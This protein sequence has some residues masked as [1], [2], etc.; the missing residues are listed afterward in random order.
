MSTP[1][2]AGKFSISQLARFGA[3]CKSTAATATRWNI[4][5]PLM[6]L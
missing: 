3:R 1:A 2:A 6:G 4:I 5:A